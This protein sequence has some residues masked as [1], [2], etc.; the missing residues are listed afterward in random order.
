MPPALPGGGHAV[1]LWPRMEQQGERGTGAL[2]LRGVLLPDEP[3]AV[4]P[5]LPGVC[6]STEKPAR[7]IAETPTTAPSFSLCPQPA[8][9]RRR[10]SLN[11]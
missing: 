5:V 3:R 9:C 7:V 10:L 8:A 4:L 2:E 11:R 6:L 1:A